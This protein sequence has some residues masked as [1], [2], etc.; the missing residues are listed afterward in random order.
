MVQISNHLM[1]VIETHPL[2]VLS[3]ARIVS[4]LLIATNLRNHR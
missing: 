4:S 2:R 1:V 3:T